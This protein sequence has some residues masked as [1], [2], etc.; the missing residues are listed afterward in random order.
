MM[1]SEVVFTLLY[2]LLSVCIVYPPIEFMSAGLTIPAM[3][4]SVLGSEE[5]QF[6]RYNIKRATLT[7]F[8]YSLL[9]IGYLLGLVTFGFSEEVSTTTVLT[10]K[11]TKRVL[12]ITI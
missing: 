6:V 4:S 12:D 2:L 9:P 8:I 1:H 7:I 11:I 10:D 3:F 5:L